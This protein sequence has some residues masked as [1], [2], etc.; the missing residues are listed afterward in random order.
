M[1]QQFRPLSVI[2]LAAAGLLLTGCLASPEA[3]DQGA[4]NPVNTGTTV[5]AETPTGSSEAAS[6][7]ASVSP[8]TTGS[9]SADGSAEDEVIL[10]RG[11]EHRITEPG[12]TNVVRCDG[13]GQVEIRA[14]NVT[15][16]VTGECQEVEIEGSENTVTVQNPDEIEVQGNS[17]TVTATDIR[18]LALEGGSN[19]AVLTSVQ[20]IDIQGTKNSVT[21]ETGRPR[22]DDE[23]ADTTING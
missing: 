14:D 7:S 11:M 8:E 21:Y 1:S 12:S 5:S 4:V 2:G 22:I 9:P 15:L 20:E 19:S 10:V 3:T 23:G 6:A 18:E 13:G 17:N 16:T